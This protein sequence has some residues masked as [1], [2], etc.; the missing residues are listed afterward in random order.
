MAGLGE[1]TRIVQL[2]VCLLVLSPVI[3]RW[4]LVPESV[5]LR[6]PHGILQVGMGW[7]GIHLYYFDISTF[8][9]YAAAPLSS[10][11]KARTQPFRGL[12][13]VPRTALPTSTTWATTGNARYTS[14][15]S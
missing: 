1:S 3:W 12:D 11:P 13:F 8:T 15:G 14:R 4:M 2:Q 5:T 7:D 9:P 6:E 10:M